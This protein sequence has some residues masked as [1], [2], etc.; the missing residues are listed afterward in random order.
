MKGSHLFGLSSSKGM[1]V[2]IWIRDYNPPRCF[3]K[4]TSGRSK[5]NDE[6]LP[7]ITSADPI[8]SKCTQNH[9]YTKKMDL[10]S[11]GVFYLEVFIPTKSY[12]K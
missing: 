1:T 10:K 11:E 3:Q 4:K 9:I 5:H 8:L 2:D 7:K 6:I 12:Q